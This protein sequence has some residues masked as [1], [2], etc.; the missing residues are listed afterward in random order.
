MD[1]FETAARIILG[2]Q[3]TVAAA[4]TLTRRLVAELGQGIDTPFA[5]LDRLFPGA[6]DDRRRRPERIGRLGIVRQ[7][8]AALQALAREV[9]DGRIELHPGAPLAGHA[10]RAA[11]AARHRRVDACS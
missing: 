2:Q 11:R 9:A 6:A 4:R 1:G 8:V 10:G 5:D 7:R 3:V